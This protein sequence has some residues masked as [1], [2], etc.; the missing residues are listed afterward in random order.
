M[1]KT[2]QQQQEARERRE[3]IEKLYDRD[4][5]VYPDVRLYAEPDLIERRLKH[6]AV[7]F[8]GYPPKKLACRRNRR[9]LAEYNLLRAKRSC[10]KGYEKTNPE[11]LPDDVKVIKCT[12]MS[13]FNS[14]LSEVR[15]QYHRRAH[16]VIL[17]HFIFAKYNVKQL[18]EMLGE[19]TLTAMS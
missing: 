3:L 17:M 15:Q 8:R 12:N 2:E 10:L 6:L 7:Q 4:A 5:A 14:T 11:D 18:R 19:P 1:S 13:V 9:L 16:T